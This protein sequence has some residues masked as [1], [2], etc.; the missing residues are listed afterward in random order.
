MLADEAGGDQ[1]EPCRHV[2]VGESCRGCYTRFQQH[3]ANLKA[4]KGFMW[5][6]LTQMHKVEPSED[7]RDDF[8][9]KRMS[10]DKDPLRRIVREAIRQRRILDKETGTVWVTAS[11]EG[12][13]CTQIKTILL[14]SK[15]EF[16]LPRMI[17]LT[18]QRTE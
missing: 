10:V 4:K 9:M 1:P 13:H 7:P 11:E 5:D 12:A 14:N 15:E 17:S 6:H 8:G 2:Y 18:D 16:H 3:L